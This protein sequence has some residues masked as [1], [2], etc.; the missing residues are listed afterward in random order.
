MHL[1]YRLPT[2]SYSAEYGRS[3][4][5]QINVVT[6][7]G[8]NDFS[9]FAYEYFRDRA[10]DACNYFDGEQKPAFNRNQFGFGAGGP[11]VRGSGRAPAQ[12]AT[13]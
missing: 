8:T 3:A 5:G 6:R 11:L 12:A 4:T 9:M 2:N 1:S 13:P 7:G 10:L